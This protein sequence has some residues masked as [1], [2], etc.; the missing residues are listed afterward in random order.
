MLLHT[1]W[2]L[3]HDEHKH[4]LG[5]VFLGPYIGWVQGVGEET[6]RDVA[7]ELH[8]AF[9]SLSVRSLGFDVESEH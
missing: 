9:G 2:F 5:T 6:L 3:E 4:L 7:Q 1:M 8:D